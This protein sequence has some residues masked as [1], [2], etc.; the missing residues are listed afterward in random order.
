MHHAL[1]LAFALGCTA[2]ALWIGRLLW[3]RGA[4][5]RCVTYGQSIAATKALAERLTVLAEKAPR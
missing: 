3:L 5:D 2:G 1:K 4:H